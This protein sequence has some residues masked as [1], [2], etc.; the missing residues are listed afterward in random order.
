MEIIFIR[1]EEKGEMGENPSLTERG[2]KQAYEP[3]PE[4]LHN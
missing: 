2:N 1:H 3:T 4:N